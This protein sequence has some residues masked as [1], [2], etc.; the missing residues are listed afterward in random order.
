MPRDRSVILLV[1]DNLD[2]V[3][4]TLRAFRK[5]NLGEH[6]VIARDGV[7]AVDFLFAQG[8]YADRDPEELP[9]LVI[10]DINLPKLSGL[11]VLR[12]IRYDQRTK[13]LPV[14]ML[15]TS[16]EQ[17]DILESYAG[18]ANSYIRKPV[19]SHSF[20]EAIRQ[21]GFYWLVLN[22]PPERAGE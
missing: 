1:E 5:H 7:E 14:V 11:D 15:T 17:R 10:L 18:G 12:R 16:N 2:D 8:A 20:A 9:H 4:L 13:T 6:V 21:L 19:D 22:E 3:E